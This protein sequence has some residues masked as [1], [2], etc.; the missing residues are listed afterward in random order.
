M[1][2]ALG[3]VASAVGN[4]RNRRD[5]RNSQHNEEGDGRVRQGSRA[6]VSEILAS[7]HILAQGAVPP[8]GG[9]HFRDPSAHSG[10]KGEPPQTPKE[11]EIPPEKLSLKEQIKFYVSLVL[12]ILASICVFALLFLIPLV[13][14]PSI[15]TLVADFDPTAATCV[16]ID[17]SVVTGLTKCGSFSSCREG[18]TSTPSQ[19]YQIYVNYRRTNKPGYNTIKNFTMLLPS[20]WMVNY[21]RASN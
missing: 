8:P 15:S 20:E 6:T 3:V 7:R 14:E 17:S 18:C 4:S 5:S 11:P 10:N 16:T 2:G 9:L 13:V 1:V 12:G 19:C 21:L